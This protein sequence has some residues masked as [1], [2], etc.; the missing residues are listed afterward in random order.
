LLP[1][2]ASFFSTERPE[3]SVAAGNPSGARQI[4]DRLP[5]AAVCI[6]ER[7]QDLHSGE[8]VETRQVSSVSAFLAVL[9]HAYCFSLQNTERK[10]QMVQHYLDLVAR[11]PILRVRFRPG[12]ERLEAILDGLEQTLTGL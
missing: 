6:L 2:A 1:D 7:T 10:R 8:A 9:A 4:G 3:E 11:T 12:L 5:L